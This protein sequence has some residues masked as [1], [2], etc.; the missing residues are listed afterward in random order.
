MEE[1]NKK[2]SVTLTPLGFIGLI[3]L[4][5]SLFYNFYQYR[6]IA[7]IEKDNYELEKQSKNL[8][9]EVEQRFLKEK[10]LIMDNKLKDAL[11]TEQD[12]ALKLGKREYKSFIKKLRYKYIKNMNNEIEVYNTL[13][14]DERKRIFTRNTG[15]K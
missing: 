5:C 11:I 10:A 15:G 14:D 12:S 2:Y 4:L 8:M 9:I 13:S 3:L 1:T 6:D 7:E